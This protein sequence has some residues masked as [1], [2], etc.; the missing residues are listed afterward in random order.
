[1]KEHK[2][3]ILKAFLDYTKPKTTNNS[4]NHCS[5]NIVIEMMSYWMRYTGKLNIEY[6]VKLHVHVCIW[7]SGPRFSTYGV[8]WDGPPPSDGGTGDSDAVVVPETNCPLSRSEMA[9]LNSHYNPLNC[10]DNFAVD[11]YI[12][13][14]CATIH[15]E[16]N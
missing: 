4:L 14:Q 11:I 1:M 3:L 9:E 7:F 5:L 6:S 13:C 8:D 12:L 2:C 16:Q 15:N 10:S